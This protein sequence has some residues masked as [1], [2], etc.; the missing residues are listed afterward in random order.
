MKEEDKLST[1]SKTMSSWKWGL[2][3]NAIGEKL[4]FGEGKET[5]GM[6]TII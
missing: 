4:G 2:F 1:R 6:F 5:Y 3:W